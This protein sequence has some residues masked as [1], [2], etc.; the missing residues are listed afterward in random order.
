[1]LGKASLWALL[2]ILV[3]LL[4]SAAM[5]IA[6]TRSLS[7]TRSLV[8]HSLE[9]NNAINGLLS[10]LQDV[11]TG[12][13]GFIITGRI[14]YLEP[15]RAARSRAIPAAVVLATLVG[16][17]PDQI[18]RATQAKQL[19]AEKLAEVDATI[20]AMRGSGFTAAQRM[21]ASDDGKRTMD[22]LRT[23]LDQMR[24]A[25]DG[26]L[27]ARIMQARS[28]ETRIFIVAATSIALAL[29]ARLAAFLIQ[30]H[31]RRKRRQSRS[32]VNQP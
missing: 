3:A 14:A 4:A 16:D 13:R 29:L 31:F 2:P 25:E 1:M 18:A 23:V 30:L 11:E 32:E 8:T 6:Y 28:A 5:N 9:V 12:Q 22:R 27:K 20:T 15:Y 10:A 26:L 21:V 24:A 7:S 19:A 17:N